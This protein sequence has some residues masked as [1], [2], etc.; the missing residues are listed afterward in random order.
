M[1]SQNNEPSDYQ[2]EDTQTTDVSGIQ[3]PLPDVDDSPLNEASYSLEVES[4]SFDHEESI[5][6][7]KELP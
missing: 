6:Q 5:N 7:L 3:A 2:L 1:V 4:K